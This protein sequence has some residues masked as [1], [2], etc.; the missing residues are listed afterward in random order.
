MLKIV[1]QTAR[2]QLTAYHSLVNR[3]DCRSHSWN[4]LRHFHEYHQFQELSIFLK[5]WKSTFNGERSLWFEEVWIKRIR[6]GRILYL[7]YYCLWN[8]YS[9]RNL[10]MNFPIDFHVFIAVIN[11]LL[12]INFGFRAIWNSLWNQ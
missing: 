2:V 3:E 6:R 9:N 7:Y 10:V 8:D 1:Y 12:S 4:F 5:V 11:L